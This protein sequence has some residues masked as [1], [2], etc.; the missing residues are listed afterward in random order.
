MALDSTGAPHLAYVDFNDSALK[1]ASRAEDGT[2][3]SVIVDQG[4]TGDRCELEIDAADVAHI[5][6][7]D[8]VGL[9]VYYASGPAIP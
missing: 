9:S 3:S 5:S 7:V 6:Y 2:W 4:N 1:Y 8:F